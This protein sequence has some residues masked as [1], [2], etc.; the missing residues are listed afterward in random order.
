MSEIERE[1]IISQRLEE[2]Q[3]LEDKRMISQMVKDLRNAEDETIAKTARR[4]WT[5]LVLSFVDLMSCRT[6]CGAG[7]DKGED[8]QAG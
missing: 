6:T 8:P 5:C 1:E 3:R 7:C 2:K 4:W